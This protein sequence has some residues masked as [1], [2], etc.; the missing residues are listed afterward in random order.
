MT[1]RTSTYS[2]GNGGNCIEAASA[3]GSVAVRDTKDRDGS[4]LS[5]PA[6]AWAKF[7]SSL[8][9]LAPAQQR[10]APDNGRACRASALTDSSTLS[11]SFIAHPNPLTPRL[12]RC[13]QASRSGRMLSP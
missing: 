2:S 12:D 13:E 4:L 7:T 10:G 5:I 3:T 11:A 8:K 6:D 1:W 9:S